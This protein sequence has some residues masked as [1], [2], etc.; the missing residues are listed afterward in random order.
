MIVK[1]VKHILNIV[2]N[3]MNVIDIY[4]IC[5]IICYNNLKKIT[6]II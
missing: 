2:K 3:I 4:I 6:N 5:I 1:A